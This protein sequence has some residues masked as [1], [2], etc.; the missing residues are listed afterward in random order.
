ME[1]IIKNNGALSGNIQVSGAK[2]SALGLIAATLLTNEE[3]VLTNVPNVSD[4][5]NMIEAISLIGGK[6]K[7]EKNT[8]IIKNENINVENPINYDCVRKIRAS[9]YLLGSLLGKYHKGIVALPGGCPI[10]TRPINLHLKGFETL[11]AKA[12]LEDGNIIVTADKLTGRFIYLDFPSVGA[13]I[14]IILAAVLAEGETRILNAAKEPH[15]IDIVNMLVK[16]GA[17]IN[18]AGTDQIKI[19]GVK[20]LHGTV[21]EVIPDQIEAGTFMIAAAMTR[22]DITLENV[23]SKHLMSISSKLIEMGVK[24]E[25]DETKIRITNNKRLKSSIV[26]TAPYPG[27]PTDLQPQIAMA[28]ALA[29]GDSIVEEKIFENRFV[30]A[31]EVARM[32]AKMKIQKSVNCITG[33]NQF[34]GATVVAPDLRAG[35]ALTLAGLCADRKTTIKNAQI[36][37]RGYEDFTEKLNSIGANIQISQ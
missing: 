1:Y 13:T 8:L 11:G 7:K 32:G 34:K 37:N 27:F 9:Y 24:I 5:D 25:E 31:D 16:M 19:T 6:C 28:L 21:H 30:Y 2:N 29:E 3:V 10:G 22:G 18:G 36:I 17:K 4:I 26:K 20:A 23:V 35:A 15:V 33:I 12:S 14:N